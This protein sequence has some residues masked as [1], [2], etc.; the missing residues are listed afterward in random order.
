MTIKEIRQ[1]TGL[2][3]QKFAEKY[4]I[5]LTS[6]KNWEVNVDSMNHRECPIYVRELL[7]RVV[8]IDYGYSD[9]NRNL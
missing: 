8:K 6:L 4:H 9:P 7:E 2:S 1:L 3:Q 5:P